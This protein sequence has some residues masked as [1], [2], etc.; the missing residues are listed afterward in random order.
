MK[1]LL[2]LFLLFSLSVSCQNNINDIAKQ[3]NSMAP[4]DYG[5][6]SLNRVFY[7]DNYFGYIY[8]YKNLKNEW[9]EDAVLGAIMLQGKEIEKSI[10]QLPEFTTIRKS[11]RSI[12]FMYNDITGKPI[13]SIVFSIVNGK[14]EIDIENSAAGSK[15]LFNSN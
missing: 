9:N 3:Y 2:A 12:V 10:N 7:D 4:I 14:Y 13:Y 6:L 15:K 11:G 5:E 8:R 1:K